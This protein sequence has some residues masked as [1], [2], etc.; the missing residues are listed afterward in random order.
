MDRDGAAR[1][2]ASR[3]QGVRSRLRCRDAPHTPMEP[4]GRRQQGRG[5]EA[6]RRRPKAEDQGGS[7]GTPPQRHRPGAK[8]PAREKP[9][10]G[11]RSVRPSLY[12]SGRPSRPALP[13][14][15]ANTARRRTRTPAPPQSTQKT[16]LEPDRRSR[17]RA[18][19]LAARATPRKGPKA[20][21]A[22]CPCGGWPVLPGEQRESGSGGLAALIAGEQE[23]PASS[24]Q[25][26]FHQSGAGIDA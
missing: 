8:A 10:V 20:G 22:A 9:K 17:F 4:V 14:P 1:P 19:E 23:P 5:L 13:N 12:Y 11:T 24:A 18:P 2:S 16:P 3:K 6:N 25:S 15:P 26:R 21:E 7:T